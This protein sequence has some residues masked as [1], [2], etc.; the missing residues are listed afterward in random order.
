VGTILYR[1]VINGG[2]PTDRLVDDLVRLVLPD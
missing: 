1:R 2:A